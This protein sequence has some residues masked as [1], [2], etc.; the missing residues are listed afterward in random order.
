MTN[1]GIST[2]TI[3][4]VIP[5]YNAALT[6]RRA[7]DSV[8]AQ[9]VAPAEIIVVDDGSPD[10]LAQVVAAYGPAVTLIRQTNSRSAAARNRGIDAATGDFIAFL[11]A[12]D[13]WEPGKLQ[14]QLAVFESHP[15]IDVVAGRYFSET[16]GEDRCLNETRLGHLYDRPLQGSGSKAFLLGTLFW[17]GT[18]L[19]RRSTLDQDRFVSGLEPAEDRDLWVR[20]AAANTV[21]LASQPLATAVLEPGS[22]SRSSIATDCT[23]MLEVIDRNARLLGAPSKQLWKSYVRYRW[24]AIDPSPA[25]S[26]PLLLRSIIGWPLPLTGMPAM[27][28][29]GRFKRLVVLLKQ[30]LKQSLKRDTFKTVARWVLQWHLPVGPLTRPLFSAMYRLHVA[31]RETIAW[32]MRFLWHEPL[33]RS[34]CQSVGHRFCMEQLPYIV[35][36]GILAIGDDVSLSGK[37]SL[38]FSSRHTDSPSLTI[39]NGTFIGHNCAITVGHSVTIGEHVLMAGGVRIS[40][41]DGHPIDAVDRRNG[42]TTPSNAVLPVTIGDDV[43]IGH[44]AII[45][46]GVHLGDRSI[47]GARSVVTKDVA[48]DTIVAGNPARA[49][50]TLTAPERDPVQ[51]STIIEEAA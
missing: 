13:Y 38:A 8:L 39:G 4:V 18:V 37:S 19:V 27:K 15:E 22:I 20:L 41:F 23:K 2:A 47:I 1:S 51:A 16:P 50:K 11:D 30:S 7:L 24:A 33:F 43:W 17:T 32:M 25:N 40:D 6:I 29:W 36:T 10:D 14:H 21:W 46:K 28:P 26:L 9:T 35:G 12:D 45:L 42:L 31:A 3:S 44:G 49:V 34:Q 5:A 48:P